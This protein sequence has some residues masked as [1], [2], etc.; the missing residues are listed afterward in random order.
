[1]L[2]ELTEKTVAELHALLESTTIPRAEFR[3]AC[4]ECSLY[5]ICLP[6]AT[7]I[8]SRAAQLSRELFKT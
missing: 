8:L 2:R 1:V 6:E 4:A 7:G 3:E 5:E